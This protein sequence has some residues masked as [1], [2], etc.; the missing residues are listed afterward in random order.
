MNG[1]RI[2]VLG[3]GSWGTALAVL[4]ARG[5]NEITLWG[6]NEER[7]LRLQRTRENI[8]YLPAVTLPPPVIV[9]SDLAACA[10]ANVIVF[11]TPSTTVRAIAETLRP[12]L[13]KHATLLSCT[14]GIEH[15]S[16]MRMSEILKEILPGHNVAVLSGPNLAIEVSRDLPTATVIG[17]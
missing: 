3:A 11:V 5:G 13:S 15:G 6:H 14:K 8:D 9:T 4:W 12:H 2:L 7:A 10:D 17:C 16:G 1:K